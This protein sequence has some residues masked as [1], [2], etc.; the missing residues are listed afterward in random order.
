MNKKN[1]II[2]LGILSLLAGGCTIETET[3]TTGEQAQ[4]TTH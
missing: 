3:P 2:Y 1:W 4:H